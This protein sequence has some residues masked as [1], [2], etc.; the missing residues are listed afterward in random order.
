V[1][2]RAPRLL[3]QNSELR[4]IGVWNWTLPAWVVELPD[5]R[6]FNVCPSAGACAQLCY[7]RN[8]TYLFPKVREAHVR[9]LTFVLDDLAGWEQ[10]ML[11]EVGS[12]RFYPTGTPRKDAAPD[13]TVLDDWLQAWVATGG[14]AVRV[15]D[16]GDYFADDYTLA[17]LRIAA[18][19]PHVLFYSYTKQVQRFRQLVEGKAPPNFRWLYSLGGREDHLIELD[20]ERHAD[21]F[22]DEQAIAQAGYVSQ[23]ASDLYAITLATPKVGIPA[24]NIRHFRKRQGGDTFG[25]LQQGRHTQHG[26]E[27]EL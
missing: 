14:Q 7:A 4:D 2:R 19:T 20:R 1:T 22:P 27:R 15:H 18:A 8:G 16:A 3:T 5:G 17:W 25:G 12:K 9:N 26:L 24:N 13:G 23:E 6:K 21:V 11:R 10:A